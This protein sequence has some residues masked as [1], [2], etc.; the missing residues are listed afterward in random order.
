MLLVMLV[1][2][3]AVLLVL[4]VIVDMLAHLSSSFEKHRSTFH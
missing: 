3:T 2:A 4:V 1:A